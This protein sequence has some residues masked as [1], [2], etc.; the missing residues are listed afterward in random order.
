[1]ET[2]LV[3]LVE[4]DMF[5]IGALRFCGHETIGVAM[6]AVLS[7]KCECCQGYG[8]SDNDCT[9][10]QQRIEEVDC[11]ASANGRSGGGEWNRK[12]GTRTRKE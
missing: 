12:F 11:D 6:V 4:R 2:D 3:R 7:N 9:I 1:M 5:K 8:E 10:V